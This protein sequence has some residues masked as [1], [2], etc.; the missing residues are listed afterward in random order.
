[1]LDRPDLIYRY[2]GSFDGLLSCVFES[3]YAHE[4]PGAIQGPECTQLALFSERNIRTDSQ[5]AMRVRTAIS[6]KISAEALGFVLNA[7]RTCLPDRELAILDFLRMGFRGGPRVLQQLSD[8]VVNKLHKAVAA[9]QSE[10]HLLTGFIRFT[11]H[12]G[13]LSCV[14]DPKND[15]L[16]LMMPHFLERYPNEVFLIFDRTHRRALGGC[17]GKGRI[18]PLENLTLP[19]AGGEERMYRAL[20]QKYYDTVAVEG[21]E[22]PVCRRSHMPKRFWK[23]MTEFQAT[24]CG[25]PRSSFRLSGGRK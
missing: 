14:I 5:H 9:L 16:P 20:W 3:F 12:D 25:G 22:N 7:F 24:A 6:Q 17:G 1:M 8:P 23:N 18:F 19:E 4:R 10:A 15:V 13:A 21:R 2:D 11:D